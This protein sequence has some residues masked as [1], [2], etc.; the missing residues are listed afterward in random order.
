MLIVY[1]VTDYRV[2][3]RV[4]EITIKKKSIKLEMNVCSTPEVEDPG[5]ILFEALVFRHHLEE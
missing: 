4:T 1:Y 5:V 3:R 2:W